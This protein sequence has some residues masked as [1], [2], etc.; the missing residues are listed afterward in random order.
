VP[1]PVQTLT[2]VQNPVVQVEPAP[3]V[4]PQKPQFDASLV[5]GMHVDEQN[6]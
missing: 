3:H 4:W 2:G 6:D 5:V 1:A